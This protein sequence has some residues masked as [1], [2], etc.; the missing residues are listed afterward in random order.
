GGGD[1]HGRD[2]ASHRP[3]GTNRPAG[4]IGPPDPGWLTFAPMSS[5]PPRSCS[6]PLTR[7]IG[8]VALAAALALSACGT[9]DD[10]E[11]GPVAVD[12]MVCYPTSVD[13]S[14][15]APKVEPI[16]KAPTEVVQKD[17]EKGK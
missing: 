2:H 7:R 12:G 9:S 4:P 17:L 15:K 13:P 16:T 5:L 10:A 6:R 3:A 8:A 14:T 11:S 1:A